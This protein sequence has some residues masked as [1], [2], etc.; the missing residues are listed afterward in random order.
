MK[1]YETLPLVARS[2]N[3]KLD[4]RYIENNFNIM[5]S[6]LP[7]T[8]PPEGSFDHYQELTDEARERLEKV[9]HCNMVKKNYRDSLETLDAYLEGTR[10]DTLL[11]LK[12]VWI[13]SRIPDNDNEPAND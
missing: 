12:D 7:A 3:G 6:S 10:G 11:I 5:S 1:S 8:K 9:L 13:E 2:V 4:Q